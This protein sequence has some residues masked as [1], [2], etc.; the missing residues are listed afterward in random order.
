MKSGPYGPVAVLMTNLESMARTGALDGA[1]L[2][3]PQLYD[4]NYTDPLLFVADGTYMASPA[5]P[6]PPG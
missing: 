4:T 5:V 6:A 3:S 2:Q 1:L